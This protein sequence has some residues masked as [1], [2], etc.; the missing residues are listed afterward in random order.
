[1]ILE[2]EDFSMG[3]LKNVT[4]SIFLTVV[5]VGFVAFGGQDW[6]KKSIDNFLH[7]T[8]DVILERAQKVGDFSKVNKEFEIEK[9][10]GIMG[11]NAVIAEH[12][13]S[14]QKMVVVDSGKKTILTQEDIKASNSEERIKSAISKF[15]YQSA[16][17]EDFHV[18][19]KGTMKSYGQE[20]PYVRFKAR[21][22]KLPIGELSGIISVVKDDNGNDK[23]L[24]SANQTDKYSQL[25][26]NEFIKEVK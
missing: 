6:I 14:G 12:K 4:R 13:A 9:A 25:I 11:Y 19:E 20:I 21:I 22:K 26:S 2:T 3:C 8:H 10:A 18:T 16:A 5:V 15:K 7:P 24:I 1:M 23:I 17:L